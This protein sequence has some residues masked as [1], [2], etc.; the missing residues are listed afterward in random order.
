MSAEPPPI[1]RQLFIFAGFG[2]CCWALLLPHWPAL[3]VVRVY[4]ARTRRFLL[5]AFGNASFEAGGVEGE[6]GACAADCA[7]V[8][9]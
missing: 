4:L 6:G 2:V 8:L 1:G 5:V 9:T 3:R 7:C